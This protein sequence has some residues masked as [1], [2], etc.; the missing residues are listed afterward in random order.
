MAKVRVHELAKELGV[1]S[2]KLLEV[3]TNS[4]EFVK[5]ASST[6]EAPVV[7]KAREYFEAHPE[8]AA[9]AKPKTSKSTKKSVSASIAEPAGEQVAAGE[10][11]SSAEAPDVAKKSVAKPKPG[12]KAA[13]VPAKPVAPNAQEVNNHSVSAVDPAADASANAAHASVKDD[14]NEQKNASVESAVK[15]EHEQSAQE[16]LPAAKP[17]APRM[18]TATPG[19]AHRSAEAARDAAPPR[20]QPRR[21]GVPRPGNSPFASRQGMGRDKGQGRAPRPGNSPFGG[22]Q[23]MGTRGGRS[24]QG[25]QGG[26]GQSTPNSAGARPCPLSRPMP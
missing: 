10:E 26:R 24:G 9:A 25:A 1:T 17:V 3:L 13:S 11:V 2:K 4:G 23:G 12:G 22:Q 19:S 21:N 8:E 6:I 5:S 14:E 16:K 18:T 7:R 15:S 20:P